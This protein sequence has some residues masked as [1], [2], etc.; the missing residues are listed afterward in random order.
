MDGFERQLE[1]IAAR[2]DSRPSLPAIS[3]PTL[4][5]VGSHDHLTPPDRSEE[6]AQAVPGARL[7]VIP[8]CGHA[9]TLEQPEAVN[10]ALVEWI[11]G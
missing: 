4:V 11:R 6:I 10:G 5:L 1:A 8:E 2:A 3:V 7:A 9:S